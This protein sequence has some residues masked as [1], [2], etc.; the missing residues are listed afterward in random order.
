[1]PMGLSFVTRD[2][3]AANIVHPSPTLIGKADIIAD[4]STEPLG[5]F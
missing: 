3:Q 5:L 1:M 2:L 4:P